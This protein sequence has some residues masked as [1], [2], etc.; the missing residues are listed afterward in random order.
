MSQAETQQLE[1][2]EHQEAPAAAKPRKRLT[3]TQKAAILL[4]TLGAEAS[5]EVF[6]L[7]KQ[8][9]VE[10][11]ANELVRQ[12]RVDVETKR[13]VFEEF[14]TLYSTSSLLSQGGVEYA[15]SVL[16]Q[17]LGPQK[18][19]SLL[20]RIITARGSE[21]S[22]W[23]QHADP[24][25]LA[26]WLASEQPQTIALV[27]TQL[28]PPRAAQLLSTLPQEVRAEVTLKIARMQSASAEV[29]A[30]I[31]DSLRSRLSGMDADAQRTVSGVQALVEILNS[32]ERSLERSV[33]ESLSQHDAALA[34][35]IKR[36]LFVFEDILLLEDR[37][38]QMVLR[39]VEQDDLRLALRGSQE[40]VREKVFKNM[41]ERASATIKEDLE[42]MGPV[43]VRDV[44]A[45]QQRIALVI[46]AMEERG[47]IVIARGEG[48]G[49]EEFV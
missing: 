18:A 25:Q 35:E 13:Q 22:D 20:E 34:E 17:A 5:A 21:P 14:E 31:E 42:T 28:P 9:E 43:R 12:E 11:L 15:R 47:E 39:E 45:A 1:H 10:K 2:A 46:R 48:E 41:S 32:A 7:L 30:Q 16:E 37:A 44:E 26:R 49:A 23:L 40:S 24:Q 4:I 8:E 29:I 19:Q 36:K 33:L 3:G 6:K 27:V 38:L